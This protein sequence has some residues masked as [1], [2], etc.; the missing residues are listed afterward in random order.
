MR[1]EHHQPVQHLA[2]WHRLGVYATGAVLLLTGLL[3]LALHYSVGARAGGLPHPMEAWSMRL[4]GLAAQA[5][6]FVLGM[7][8]AVHLPQGWSLSRRRRWAAQRRTGLALCALAAALA[9]T[10]Y[11]L[12]Y[13]A[14]Q[15]LRPTL[16]WAHAAA[17]AA[18]ALTV[19]WHR[20]GAGRHGR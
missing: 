18:M 13:F 8:A 7:V 10:G 17:G 19:A 15:W 6:M 1:P 5:G 14:P 12:D 4:H 3:W 11:L 20:L 2:P 9:A 16:G